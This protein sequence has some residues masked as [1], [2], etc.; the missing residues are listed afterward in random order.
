VA[1]K[2]ITLADKVRGYNMVVEGLRLN[3][4][5]IYGA[6]VLNVG[7]K[8]KYVVNTDLKFVLRQA[9]DRLNGGPR[10]LLEQEITMRVGGERKEER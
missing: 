7:V 10:R 8:Y 9:V 1:G 4:L 6:K 3:G 2:R 5:E